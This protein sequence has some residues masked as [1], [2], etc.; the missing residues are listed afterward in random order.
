MKKLSILY[1]TLLT[2]LVP[3]AANAQVK[4]TNPLG[5]VDVR[6]LIGRVIQGALAV[7]GSIALLMFLYGG[8]MWLTSGGNEERI[9]KGKKVLIWAVFGIIIITSAYVLTN[10]LF[11]VLLDPGKLTE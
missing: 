1:V 10:T 5:E 2:L 7:S 3:Y 8:I 11:Q 4:L 9:T 6:L